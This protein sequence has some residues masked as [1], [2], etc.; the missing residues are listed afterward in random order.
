[1]STI[2]HDIH[3]RFS[4]N[5]QCHSLIYQSIPTRTIIVIKAES[6]KGLCLNYDITVTMV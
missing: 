4:I 5:G 2:D 3:F 6:V 1:M